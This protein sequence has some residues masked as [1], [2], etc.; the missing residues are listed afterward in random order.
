[1]IFT[2]CEW[3][4]LQRNFSIF[5]KILSELGF[6]LLNM[7]LKIKMSVFSL[8]F[9]KF[10]Q[11]KYSRW[12]WKIIL[13]QSY[14][15]SWEPELVLPSLWPSFITKRTLHIFNDFESKY[16][17]HS[18]KDFPYSSIFIIWFPRS[19]QRQGWK[20]MKTICERLLGA[21]PGHGNY[22]LP[23]IL[24]PELSCVAVRKAQKYSLC[25]KG[26]R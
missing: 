5:L 1:M 25:V 2:I 7:I 4:I 15:D 18:W 12:S 24:L 14:L 19:S 6:L 8:G 10:H 16:S 13:F 21:R 23:H 3:D 11:C 22:N 17:F 9:S 20:R 26:K